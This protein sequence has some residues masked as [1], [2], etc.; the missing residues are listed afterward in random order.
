VTPPL[1]TRLR[2][3]PT[4][5]LVGPADAS[6]VVF[7]VQSL[8]GWDAVRVEAPAGTSVREV[9]VASLAALEPGAAPDLF[10]VK[11]KGHEVIDEALGLDAVGVRDGSILSVAA[12][13]RRPVR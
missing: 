8:D 1:S 2:V 9:K 12:R 5:V 4:P 10:V 11:H 13:R 6:R 7:R 3:R